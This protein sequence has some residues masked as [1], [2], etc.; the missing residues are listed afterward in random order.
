MAG[1]LVGA[2][3]S[4]GR[5]LALQVRWTDRHGAKERLHAALVE[6][7]TL[8]AELRHALQ[9]VKTLSGPL[10]VCAWCHKIRNDPGYWQRIETYISHHS[11]A[12]FT[13]GMCPEC[14]DKHTSADET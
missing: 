5:G 2:S 1:S 12:T 10:P 3:D 11:A 4:S 9:N 13:H 8:V 14:F 6:N 7:E